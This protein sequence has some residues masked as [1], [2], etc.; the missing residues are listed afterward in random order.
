MVGSIYGGILGM[1][2]LAGDVFA[3]GALKQFQEQTI[4]SKLLQ[5]YQINGNRY[6]AHAWKKLG[7]KDRL[8]ASDLRAREPTELRS[9]TMSAY[10]RSSHSEAKDSELRGFL[11]GNGIAQSSFGML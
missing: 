4:P 9:G 6:S 7:R 5:P 2:E 10:V 11:W 1:T 8:F 3:E